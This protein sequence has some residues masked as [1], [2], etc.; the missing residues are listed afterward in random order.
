LGKFIRGKQDTDEIGQMTFEN[1]EV[2]SSLFNDE[3]VEHSVHKTYQI[4]KKIHCFFN[5]I[6]N[7]NCRS[8]RAHQRVLY[9]QFLVNMTVNQASSSCYFL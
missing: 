6:R 1:E 9:E 3:E 4:H 8:A 5:Q 7:G 2:T